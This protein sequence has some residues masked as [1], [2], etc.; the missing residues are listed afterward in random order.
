MSKDELKKLFVHSIPESALP[1]DLLQLFAACTCARPEFEGSTKDR[2][3]I[4]GHFGLWLLYNVILTLI[5]VYISY[6][7]DV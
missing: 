5:Y 7:I 6:I 1:A 2:K 3:G 4:A